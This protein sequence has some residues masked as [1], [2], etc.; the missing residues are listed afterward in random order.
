MREQPAAA[1]P[2]AIYR[3]F[4]TCR[5]MRRYAARRMPKFAYDFVDTGAELE[6][7]VRRN[8][9]AFDAIELMPRFGATPQDPLTAAELFGRSY[10]LPVGVAPMGLTGLAWPGADLH[11][12]QAAQHARIPYVLAT[13]STI[14]IERAAHIAPDVFW[15]QLY[16][17]PRDNHALGL[18]LVRRARDAGAHVL[19]LTLDSAAPPKRP[20][21][22][23]NGLVP[24]FRLTP[25]MAL[26][27]ALAPAW[28]LALAR[29]G[30]PRFENV[31]PYLARPTNPW[32]T[33]AFVVREVTGAFDWD[34][35]ARI[36]ALWPRALV[37]KGLMHPADA[38]RAV[39]LGADGIWVSNHGARV[40]D[41]A[42]ASV[43]A[44]PDIVAAVRGA[45]TVLVDGGVRSG[46]D[47][48]RARAL[49]AAA[50]FAGR[51]FMFA[52]AALGA[53]GPGH[54]IR[55]MADDIRHTLQFLGA[56]GID[57]VTANVLAGARHSQFSRRS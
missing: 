57:E 19:V 50:A 27:A 56:A 24:P 1:G 6:L 38:E 54:M 14:S 13:G 36:R 20:R 18:D 16:R 7:G 32:R 3:R 25:R 46:I 52:T 21:D 23:K 10:A 44:L 34:E 31:V 51:A 33:G 12:A 53:A 55:L 43:S 41:P 39:A 42:P 8:A 4:P 26:Q 40:F 49:G 28:L 5:Q 45:A 47:V 17:M 29:H 35:V 37:V 15:F 2:D 9:E 48:V 22:L 11:L 30:L